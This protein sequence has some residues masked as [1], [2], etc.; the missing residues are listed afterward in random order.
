MEDKE[1]KA[2]L[3]KLSEIGAC[4]TTRQIKRKLQKQKLKEQQQEEEKKNNNN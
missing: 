3:E 1:H 4:I 2:L